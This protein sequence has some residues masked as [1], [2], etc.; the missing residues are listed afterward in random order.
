MSW[1]D[2]E[3]LGKRVNAQ[4]RKLEDPY[5]K[6]LEKVMNDIFADQKKEAEANLL[7]FMK[8]KGKKITKEKL[9]DF[10]DKSKWVQTTINLFTPIMGD[11]FE[12]QGK[13]AYRNL[14][15]DPTDFTIST[16]TAQ[17]FLRKNSKKFAGE[18]TDHTSQLIR[19][20][21]AT[22]LEEGDA[23]PG[24]TERIA[25]MSGFSDSRAEMIALTETHRTASESE[26][27]AWEESEVVAKKIWY[28]ALDE[29]VCEDCNAMHGTEI[30]LDEEFVS[31]RDL[32]AMGY[33]DYDG[34]IEITQLHP[35]C[36]C[37]A[38]PVLKD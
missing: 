3:V 10:I 26:L 32:Q 18:V 19:D 28:T 7:K 35:N 4:Q 8:T 17:E 37:T 12:K 2:F 5:R 20:E 1:E 11:L 38:I 24:L 27:Q 36:R 21:I 29:R 6:R 13:I 34:P 22:G 33:S 15:L 23:I 25:G 31:V 16:P 14:G 9:P 30:D